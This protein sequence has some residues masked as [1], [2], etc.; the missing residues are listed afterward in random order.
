MIGEGR[1]SR[2]LLEEV[3]QRTLVAEAQTM[4][5]P[6]L[7]TSKLSRCK[8]SHFSNNLFLNFRQL[9]VKNK[10][11]AE[12]LKKKLIMR[13]LQPSCKIKV[14]FL[15]CEIICTQK[16]VG[17]GVGSVPCAGALPPSSPR[18]WRVLRIGK[19]VPERRARE[20]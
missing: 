14:L 17:A 18:W 13:A 4:R 16:S 19:T 1:H 11:G 7:A 3:G 15:Q 8:I 9:F 5:I 6:H 12:I 20:R 2:P 10:I